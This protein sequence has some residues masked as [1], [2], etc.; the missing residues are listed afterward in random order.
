MPHDRTHR[1]ALSIDRPVKGRLLDDDPLRPGLRELLVV[2]R[3]LD[4]AEQQY[5]L[6]LAER[7]AVHNRTEPKRKPD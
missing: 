3:A 2:Y 4:P 7:L 6:D 5:L 1:P